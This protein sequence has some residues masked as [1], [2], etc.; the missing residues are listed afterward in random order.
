MKG[1]YK[2]K[3]PNGKIY[4]GQTHNIDTRFKSYKRGCPA[5]PKLNSSLLK[6]GFHNHSFSIIH[7]LPNDI[8]QLIL[9][10]YEDIYLEQYKSLSFEVLNLR[11]AGSRGLHSVETKNKMKGRVWSNYSIEKVRKSLIGHIV[12][13]DTRK[14]IS[15]NVKKHLSEN[16]EIR[17][18]MSEAKKGIPSHKKGKKIGRIQ[19]YKI[20]P[21]EKELKYLSIN[22]TLKSIGL[23]YNVSASTIKDWL[24]RLNIEYINKPKYKFTTETAQKALL[25]RKNLNSISY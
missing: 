19:P 9:D 20:M 2:I 17:I 13:D 5:Q 3:S 10:N 1:I 12:S 15:E 18:K 22:N 8:E 4:I 25:I 21:N 14:K 11:N 23:I 16:P 6:Y 7:E 24:K